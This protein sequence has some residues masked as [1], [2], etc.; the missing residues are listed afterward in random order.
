M[1]RSVF[2]TALLR[3][4]ESL[5]A[6]HL[7]GRLTDLRAR[8][9]DHL[10]YIPQTSLHDGLTGEPDK[11]DRT[12]TNGFDSIVGHILHQFRYM[13]GDNDL[14]REVAAA[15]AS[16]VRLISESRDHPG[17]PEFTMTQDRTLKAT[18]I[19]S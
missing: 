6:P 4:L 7:T 18:L 11:R 1:S 10:A 14:S 19:E 5:K 3:R 13:Y 9:E 8:I 16:F 12:G 2:D 15:T 17:L